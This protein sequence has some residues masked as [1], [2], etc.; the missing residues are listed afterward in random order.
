MTPRQPSVTSFL[1]SLAQSTHSLVPPD[2]L[3]PL[4][5]KI[6]NEF[7]SEAAAAEIAS[8]G[9]NAIREICVRQPLAMNDTLLQD[10]V[11]YKKSKDKG[12]MMAAKGLLSLYREVGAEL[13]KRRDRGKDASI[14]LRAGDRKEKRFGEEEAGEIEGLELLEQWKEEQKRAKREELGLPVEVGDGQE[15]EDDEAGWSEWEVDEDESDDSGGWLDVE[16]DHDIEVSDD[17]DDKA[18]QKKVKL[19]NASEEEPDRSNSTIKPTLSLSDPKKSTLATTK[20]LTPADLAKLQ[21]LRLQADIDSAMNGN[22]SK[23]LKQLEE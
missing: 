6:A 13:L 16:S 18:V 2:V 11:M 22:K 21:E 1:A 14:G 7:V 3:E 10:L 8:A 5:L 20:I 9:L 23:R 19:S 4:V 15:E 12:V 17:E